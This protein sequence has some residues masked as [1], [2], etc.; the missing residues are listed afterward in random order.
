MKRYCDMESY[1]SGFIHDNRQFA[2]IDNI[3]NSI[4]Y[5]KG[6]LL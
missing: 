2:Y 3:Y 4:G 5:F 1:T 6:Y